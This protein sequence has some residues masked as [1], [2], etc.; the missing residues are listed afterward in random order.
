MAASR[1]SNNRRQ[2]PFWLIVAFLVLVAFTGGSS[3]IDV[4][5]LLVL[6]PAAML[7]CAVALV[8]FNRIHLTGRKWL[9]AGFVTL[10]ALILL[11]LLP[12][13]PAVW[14]ALPGRQDIV[15]SDALV[16]LAQQWRPITLTPLNA[17][18]S[19]VSLAVPLA[20]LLLAA[21]LN[22][23]NLLRLLPVAIAIGALSGLVGLLQAI[24][25]QGRLLDPYNLGFERGAG[26]LFANRNHAA[27]M[28]AM[29][30]PMLAAWVKTESGNPSRHRIKAWGAMIGAAIL[31]PL[32][33]VTGSRSGLFLGT[34]GLISAALIVGNGG[35]ERAIA[36]ARPRT[37]MIAAGVFVGV[38]V[39]GLI[40]FYFARAEAVVRL[41]DTATMQD[42][43][44]ES[45]P[46]SKALM[47][48]YLPIGAGAGSFV[49]AYQII[50]PDSQLNPFYWNHAHNDFLETAITF[51][52]PGLGLLAA[53]G[54]F[55]GRRSLAL[56]FGTKVRDRATITARMASVLIA[57]MAMASVTD[58]PVRTPII[59][60]FLALCC[61]WL[62]EPGRAQISTCG[63][64]TTDGSAS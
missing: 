46:V 4:P 12:L 25:T 2:Y 58:Y 63:P 61:L 24:G 1:E 22:R 20:V 53:A 30:F 42:A 13:P 15:R 31:C 38:V 27:L 64:A 33:L 26:G 37:L 60:S 19:L 7:A 51:G 41:F 52:I 50:E 8:T 10:V 43:R 23:N 35:S 45:W 57:M 40:T 18:H 5:E 11:H 34:V 59:M 14:H 44:F 32:I 9:S 47:I 49:E 48:K 39:L 3:R 62:V 55:F 56:W 54:F 6:R 17:V 21:Q 16:G 36:R 28:L 29:M